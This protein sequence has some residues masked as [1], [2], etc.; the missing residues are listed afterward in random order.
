MS[1]QGKSQGWRPLSRQYL[2][3]ITGIDAWRSGSLGLR[4]GGDDSE[5][6]SGAA[7]A[8][9]SF[10]GVTQVVTLGATSGALR[11]LALCKPASAPPDGGLAPS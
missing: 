11:D 8:A 10:G 9:T 2:G 1:A 4:V 3:P 7:A 6:D 5:S